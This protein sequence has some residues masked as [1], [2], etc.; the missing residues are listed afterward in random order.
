MK[1][2]WY[3]YAESG[4]SF[5][6]GSMFTFLVYKVW[7]LWCL[8]VPFLLVLFYYKVFLLWLL[9]LLVFPLLIYFGGSQ[10]VTWIRWSWFGLYVPIA[11]YF[12]FWQLMER[13]L[14]RKLMVGIP[15]EDLA[16]LH[17]EERF[18]EE[19]DDSSGNCD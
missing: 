9:S 6:I 19:K 15:P 3:F 7:G 12:I 8:I 4:L 13:E 11:L 10:V 5:L 14:R 18:R 16:K 17:F 2:K 1:R